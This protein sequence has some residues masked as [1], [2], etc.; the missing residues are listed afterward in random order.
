MG[1]PREEATITRVTQVDFLAQL[2]ALIA[3]YDLD[4]DGWLT[5]DDWQRIEDDL[6]KAS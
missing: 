6:Q 5:E 1:Q 2:A 3:A 4:G